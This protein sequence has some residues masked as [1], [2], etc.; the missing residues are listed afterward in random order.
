[1]TSDLNFMIAIHSKRHTFLAN[2][3]QKSQ[4]TRRFTTSKGETEHR[5]TSFVCERSVMEDLITTEFLYYV[6]HCAE[7]NI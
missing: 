1:M 5:E 7:I 3:N 4:I 6:Q 2:S